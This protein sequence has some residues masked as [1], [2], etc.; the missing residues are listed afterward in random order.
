[1]TAMATIAPVHVKHRR[2]ATMLVFFLCGGCNYRER[3]PLPFAHP[4]IGRCT[5]PRCGGQ[6]HEDPDAEPV[7]SGRLR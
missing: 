7:G 5:C 4:A 1:M 3:W 2:E 6:L